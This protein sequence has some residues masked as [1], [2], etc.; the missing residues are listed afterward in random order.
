MSS[1]EAGSP[2]T[3]QA[4]A[5][6]LWERFRLLAMTIDK[7]DSFV[8]LAPGAAA[9]P[10]SAGEGAESRS[11]SRSLA[12]REDEARAVADDL[13]LR[14]FRVA[15]APGQFELLSQ[16]PR[17]ES[18]SFAELEKKTGLNR[19][20]LSERV[21]DLIQVGLAIREPTTVQLTAAGQALVD[22]LQT[23]QQR[24]FTRI[25]QPPPCPPK[26]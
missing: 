3:A 16:L 17:E 20:S 4:I 21:N 15:V 14:C 8:T 9:V 23:A 7:L 1:G 10:E 2:E 11:W 22:F 6:G 5:E 19:L 13:V 25:R 24:L 26:K 18:V 12:E